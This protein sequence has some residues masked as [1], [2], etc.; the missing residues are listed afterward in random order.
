MMLA[1]IG[2]STWAINQGSGQV[3]Q[4]VDQDLRTEFPGHVHHV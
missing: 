3:P 2:S 1:Y 4:L